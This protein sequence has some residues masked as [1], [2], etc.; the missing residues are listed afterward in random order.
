M[1]P[2]N[3]ALKSASSV[4]FAAAALRQRWLNPMTLARWTAIAFEHARARSSGAAPALA[5]PAVTTGGC[6]TLVASMSLR[7]M[8]SPRLRF[9]L[10][11]QFAAMRAALPPPAVVLEE[12]PPAFD[13]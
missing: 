13:V 2:W 12:P 1:L 3:V 9:R 8:N 6:A 7:P 5:L 11:R 4:I 10:A